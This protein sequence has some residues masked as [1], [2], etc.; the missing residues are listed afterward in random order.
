MLLTH[1]HRTRLI[2]KDAVTHFQEQLSNE[3]WDSIYLNDINGIL[4]L[5]LN[6]TLKIFEASFP[7]MCIMSGIVTRLQRALRYSTYAKGVYTFSIETV[8]TQNVL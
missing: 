1:T 8:V 6:T 5:F 4:M 3:S 7:I 2:T